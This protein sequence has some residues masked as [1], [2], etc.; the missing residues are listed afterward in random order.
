[1]S[2]DTDVF[3]HQFSLDMQDGL[4]P[5]VEPL[6]LQDQESDEEVEICLV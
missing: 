4:L 6:V 3:G 1:M 5:D 2:S